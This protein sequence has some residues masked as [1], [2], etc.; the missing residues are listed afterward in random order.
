MSLPRTQGRFSDDVA[1]VLR[2]AG[3]YEGRRVAAEAAEVI[4]EVCE[5]IG[6][7]HLTQHELVAP[8][9]TV[10]TEFFGLH[11][12]PE[13]PGR[14]CLRSS[15]AIDPRLAAGS[16]EALGDLG[17]LLDTTLFPIGAEGDRESIV[18]IDVSGRVFALDNMGEWHLGDSIESAITTLIN[19]IRPS[20][21]D[22]RGHW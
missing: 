18:A 20:R 21:L 7:R 22:D 2:A 15:F 12:L 17:R 1:S 9:V 8:A 13:G 19:G 5:H 6:G 3:W 10:L 11:L 4:R 14:Q 16:V